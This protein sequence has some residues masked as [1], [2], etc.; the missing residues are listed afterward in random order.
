M[1]VIGYT[2]C[3]TT[4]QGRSGLGLAA[5]REAIED[6]CKRSAWTLVDV[7]ED[8]ASG[9]SMRK[10]DGLARALTA[11]ESGSVEGIVAAKLDRLSRSVLDFAHLVCRAQGFGWNLVVLDLGLD[12]A[13][14]QGRLTAHILCAMAEFER[15][16]IGQRTREGLGQ[17]RKRGVQL[18]R[19]SRVP[20]A[21]AD[22]IKLERREGKTLAAIALELNAESIST[23]DGGKAWYPAGVSR[24]LR[25]EH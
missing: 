12:L 20:A 21:V 8:V 9:K 10:R 14:P 1:R 11:V 7:V 25:R 16:M 3:S 2:R 24:V 17:A 19:P 22:R 5:Q 23:P 18:G 4:E 6:A 13:T 15:E